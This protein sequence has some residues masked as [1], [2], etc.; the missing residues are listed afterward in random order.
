M[1]AAAEA[2]LACGT[3]SASNKVL[4]FKTLLPPLLLEA[5]EFQY[6]VPDGLF[7]RH[8]FGTLDE[9]YAD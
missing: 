2:F 4:G 6:F 8:F 9:V 3:R 1:G 7:H 5:K